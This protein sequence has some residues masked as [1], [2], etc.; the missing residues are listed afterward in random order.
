LCH[1][2]S[3]VDAELIGH[4]YQIQISGNKNGAAVGKKA[5]QLLS[6]DSRGFEIDF[7]PDK[8]SV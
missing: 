7:F 4:V 8:V 6:G 2:G 1:L 5:L 3:I